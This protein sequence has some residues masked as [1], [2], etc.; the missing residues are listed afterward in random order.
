MPSVLPIELY[1]QLEAV[2]GKDHATQAYK[3]AEDFLGTIEVQSKE[4]LRV[5][6]DNNRNALREE[7]RKE[8]ASKADLLNT[9]TELQAEIAKV[10][11]ELQAEIAK[12]KTELQA[13]ILKVKAELQLEMSRLERKFTIQFLLLLV[14]ILFVN[15]DA[16]TFVAKLAGLLK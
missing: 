5:L 4:A 2:I 7:L 10:K 11:T 3:V 15:R 16:L 6:T 12:V 14:A 8:L 13:E 9:K 1:Q